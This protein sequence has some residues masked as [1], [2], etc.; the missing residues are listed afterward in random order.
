MNKKQKEKVFTLSVTA[1]DVAI[2]VLSS[3]L[4]I[5]VFGIVI[6]HDIAFGILIALMSIVWTLA[7][8]CLNFNPSRYVKS[9][10]E[11]K[12]EGKFIDESISGHDHILHFVINLIAMSLGMLMIGRAS[13]LWVSLD[14]EQHEILNFSESNNIETAGWILCTASLYLVVRS[15]ILYVKK[16]I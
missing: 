6:T 7:T 11:E 15:I 12:E 13:L 8:R 10:M 5:F 14:G 16:K 9:I 3:S 1:K 4:A 2:M